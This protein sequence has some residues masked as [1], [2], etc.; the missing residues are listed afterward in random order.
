MHSISTRAS[1]YD[2]ARRAAARIDTF[3]WEGLPSLTGPLSKALAAAGVRHIAGHTESGAFDDLSQCSA[4][5]ETIPSSLDQLE[6]SPQFS[7]TIKGLITREVTEPDEL[8]DFFGA[9][10][11]VG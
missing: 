7:E 1:R 10:A 6:P 3:E 2:I 9:V 5:S 11:A 8:R 4:W